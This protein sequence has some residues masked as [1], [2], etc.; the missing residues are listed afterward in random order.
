MFSYIIRRLMF[1]LVTVFGVSIIVFLVMRI[2]PGDPLVAVFGPDGFAYTSLFVDSA[3][4]KWKLA[5]VLE[6]G[7][8]RAGDDPK[9]QQFGPIVLGLMQGAADLA[10]S[11]TYGR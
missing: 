2:L 5:I 4:A 7:F 9:L 1:G 10:E 8:Q 6:Q 11:S 3:I